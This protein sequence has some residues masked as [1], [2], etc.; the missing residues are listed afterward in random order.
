MLNV[1]FHNANYR[2]EHIRAGQGANQTSFLLAQRDWGGARE[3]RPDI[4]FI[5]NVPDW[6]KD[7]K[8]PA[9]VMMH[10]GRFVIDADSGKPLNDYPDMPKLLSSRAEGWLLE[11][12][13]RG[14]CRIKQ[15]DFVERMPYWSRPT[16]KT[17]SMRRSRFR[18]EACLNA[19]VQRSASD[20]H[21]AYNE[22][23]VPEEC[24]LAN[25]TRDP[26]IKDLTKGEIEEMKKENKGKFPNKRRKQ[27]RG[28][29]NG[30]SNGAH[31]ASQDKKGVGLTS[32]YT[33]TSVATTP[34]TSVADSMTLLLPTTTITTPA[35]VTGDDTD[36][37]FAAGL[38]AQL[39]DT[40]DG[41]FSNATKPYESL[42]D[43]FADY[44]HPNF[45]PLG[46]QQDTA[47]IDR[48]SFDNNLDLGV[49]DLAPQAASYEAAVNGYN[50]AP[51][52]VGND[53]RL[54]FPSNAAEKRA[55]QRALAPTRR[56][57]MKILGI[58]STH[59][60]SDEMPYYDQYSALVNTYSDGLCGIFGGPLLAINLRLDE[61]VWTEGIPDEYFY[62]KVELPDTS[63][64]QV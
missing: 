34:H 60:T 4:L 61:E 48:L 10:R 51:N 11:A 7:P 56:E 53:F 63:G 58:A 32:S 20:C 57:I 15:V 1:F 41:I 59:P 14:H 55:I 37:S 38:T 18:W 2:L 39:S 26:R 46:Y 50:G 27:K 47:S 24:K 45:A 40:T 23:R 35:T 3:D 16:A 17:L 21:I 54:Y 22:A 28:A 42:E 25:N 52:N 33:A 13:F 12:L 6:Y 19:W 36:I 8:G 43:D 29:S 30:I 5:L 64:P 62:D 44:N 9:P 31:Q 49:S